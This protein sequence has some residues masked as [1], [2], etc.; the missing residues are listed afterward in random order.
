MFEGF[1]RTEIETPQRFGG[2]RI[3]LRSS[4]ATARR[5][6]CCTATR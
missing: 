2:A 3:H 1:T 5:S 6:C 4:A